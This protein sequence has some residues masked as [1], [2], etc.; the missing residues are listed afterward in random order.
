MTVIPAILAVVMTAL[1]VQTTAM[2]K[3]CTS[4]GHKYQKEKTF[5]GIHLSAHRAE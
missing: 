5:S 1:R 4:T 2:R 3:S